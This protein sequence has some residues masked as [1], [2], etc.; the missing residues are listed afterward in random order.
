VRPSR[1]I[2]PVNIP[3]KRRHTGHCRKR[4]PA[5]PQPSSQVIR[6]AARPCADAR[7]PQQ[8]ERGPDAATAG[9]ADAAAHRTTRSARRP[10]M[11]GSKPTPVHKADLEHRPPTSPVTQR[12]SDF[13][14]DVAPDAVRWLA[15]AS[16][17]VADRLLLFP[18]P[19]AFWRCADEVARR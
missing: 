4:L 7:N 5:A 13:E 15:A 14:P 19:N 8:S 11:N 10:L 2:R 18:W 16:S 17:S 6:R 12:D 3:A 9:K 1:K